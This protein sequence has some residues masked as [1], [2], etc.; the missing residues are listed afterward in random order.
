MLRKISTLV[1]GLCFYLSLFVLPAQAADDEIT[2]TV[3]EWPPFL[4][5]SLEEGGVIAQLIKAVF[6][7]DGVDAN[8]AFLPW[9]RGYSETSEGEHDAMG[10]W[11]HKV[12]REAE[13]YYSD[14]VLIEKFVFFHR[15]DADFDWQTLED[16]KGYRLGGG[17]KYSYGAEFDKALA[18]GLF[19]MD[20]APNDEINFKKLLIDRVQLYPQEISVGYF[21]MQNKL[22]KEEQA[23]ITHHPKAILNNESFVL[24]PKS[25]PGSK[26]LM[27][28]F[29]RRLKEFRE[30]GKYQLFIDRLKPGK[31]S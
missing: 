31:S 17:I 27:A 2:V 4:S 18:S 11:M 20:R 21:A 7:A 22:S 1:I 12:E 10:V 30:T 29:N 15:K 5:Q 26:A 16:I 24:F 13:F 25:L 19:S 14:P 9:G 23:Q 3:G 28:R 8:I 6:A